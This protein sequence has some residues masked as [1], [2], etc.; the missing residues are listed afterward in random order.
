MSVNNCHS[1]S[2]PVSS[3]VPQGS[4]LG[5]ILFIYFINDLPNVIKCISRIFA[6]DT[7]AYKQISDETDH[8]IVQ[9]SIDAMVEWG[10]KW[11]SYFNSDK[12]GVMH[13]G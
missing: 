5:P 9:N 7:K 11:L 2:I 12:C 1:G 3:G 13:I 4:V 8:L 10:D 6:D